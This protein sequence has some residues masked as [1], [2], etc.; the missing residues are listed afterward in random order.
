MESEP[1][2]INARAFYVAMAILLLMA[3]FA[4]WLAHYTSSHQPPRLS[5]V[6]FIASSKPIDTG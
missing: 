3:L 5:N 6:V 2:G 1:K 4:V